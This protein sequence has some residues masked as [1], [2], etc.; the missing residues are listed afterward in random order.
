MMRL[1]LTVA[2]AALLLTAC[3]PV[4]TYYT[5][6]SEVSPRPRYY[7]T[8]STHHAAPTQQ[9][10]APA[11]PDTVACEQVP[12]EADTCEIYIPEHTGTF[13][14]VSSSGAMMTAT[15]YGRQWHGSPTS[16]GEPYDADKMTC[17]H[18]RYPFGTLLRVTNPNTG[19][20]VV[21]RVNDRGPFV[22]GR[23]ID[24]SDAAAEAIG[25]K[26]AGIMDVMVEEVVEE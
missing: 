24:L 5:P 26:G 8:R 25:M 18:K 1:A 21:V 17:A 11:E 10:P 22:P 4:R 19:Q 2:A 7:A 6:D 14:P 20:W 9:E 16:S 23:D 12:V 13:L 3:A 15:Y